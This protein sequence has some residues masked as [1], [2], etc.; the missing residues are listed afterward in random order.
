M[1][2]ETHLCG[3]E[4]DVRRQQLARFLNE[5]KL[6]NAYVINAM[7]NDGQHVADSVIELGLDYDPKGG[8]PEGNSPRQ[9]FYGFRKM[10]ELGTFRC[11]D[12]SAY[13]AAVMEIK[14]GIPTMVLVVPQGN[15]EY[16]GIYV[17]STG[18]VDPTENWLRYWEARM[19]QR[20]PK[21]SNPAEGLKQVEQLPMCRIDN[22][23]V[24]CTGLEDHTGC[25]V[26]AD[27]RWRCPDSHP[28]HGKDA[29][30][31]RYQKR[32]KQRW[33][34][35]GDDKVPVPVCPRPRRSA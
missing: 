35:V 31:R 14:Y 22:G 13:E 7:L 34:I 4:G 2:V 17:T 19:A 8:T 29:D 1:I 23:K 20:T 3:P 33:A 16:H 10:M 5:L 18:A 27:G 24:E 9:R 12:A 21:V 25:C 6:D 32:G 15:T 30:V 11:G 28:L 26:G